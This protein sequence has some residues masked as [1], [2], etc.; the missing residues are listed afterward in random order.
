MS[1]EYHGSWLFQYQGGKKV[2]IREEGHLKERRVGLPRGWKA[3]FSKQAEKG[4][5]D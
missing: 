4:K 3:T 5:R 2:T 1:R